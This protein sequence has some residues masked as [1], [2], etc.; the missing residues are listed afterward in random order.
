MTVVGVVRDIR[1]LGPS[2][3]PRPE[4]YQSVL[5]RS[6][7][8]LAFVV[9]TAPDPQ[10]LAPAIRA[11]VA[12][13]DPNLPLSHVRTMEEH[14][15]KNLARPRFLSTLVS[16][17]GA[18]AVSLALV[19]VY[20]MMAW[21]VT[22]RRQEIAIRMALGARRGE[23][24]VMVLRRALVLALTGLALGLCA[25]PA[26]TRVLTGLLYGVTATDAAAF[27]TPAIGLPA[28]AVLASLGPA[29]RASRVEPG[30][31]VRT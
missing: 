29:L 31:L 5:Q 24:V 27:L 8:F 3:P 22:E 18:L 9:R 4:L 6:F 11:A 13:L 20:G 16:M 25:A 15:T 10:A 19:G 1:H 21:S 7:P 17:F 23:M 2:N 28:V 26:A 14:L 12:E 30:A